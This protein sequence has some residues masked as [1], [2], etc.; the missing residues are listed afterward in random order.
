MKRFKTISA[1]IIGAVTKRAHETNKLSPNPLFR[2][3]EYRR[4]EHIMT[5]LLMSIS[6]LLSLGFSTTAFAEPIITTHSPL[7]GKV[8][9]TCPARFARCIFTFNLTGP[10]GVN[11]PGTTR[12]ST[13]DNP[14]P[15]KTPPVDGTETFDGIR[16]VENG[17][18]VIDA[19]NK[20]ELFNVI[21]PDSSTPGAIADL[22]IEAVVF[23][24]AA[25]VFVLESIFG[26]LAE[27]LGVGVSVTIPD[28]FADTNGDGIIGGGD[29]LYSLVDL[30]VYLNSVPDFALG[31]TFDIINGTVAGLTGMMFS[32]TPFSFD[33]NRGFSSGTP[34]SGLGETDSTHE[35]SAIPEPSSLALVGASLIVLIGVSS[36]NRI[37]ID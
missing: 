26:R 1:F 34:F 10:E 27:R 12:F 19:R 28:L 35:I 24:P 17:V 21:P 13:V 16:D 11:I 23:D 6:L 20:T 37:R 14:Q 22:S 25:N 2:T 5:R 29:L 15:P 3:N 4:G 36:R 32:S 33:A 8:I 9:E 7:L 30:N 18:T 31:D